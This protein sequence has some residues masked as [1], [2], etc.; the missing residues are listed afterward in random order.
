M[1][2][3]GHLIGSDRVSTR[4]IDR[5][6]FAHDASLYRMVPEAVIRPS[7]SEDVKILLDWCTRTKRHVTFRAAGTSLSGQAV[8]D[9]ILVDL[10][11]DWNRVTVLDDGA[12]IRMQPGITG[13]RVNAHLR[14]FGRKIGPDPASIIAAM[15]GG[16]VANNASGMCCGT[17]QN[18][19][20][21]LSSMSYILANG[22]EIDTSDIDADAT[23]QYLAPDIHAGL[24][25][26]RDDVR[27][28]IDLVETI[29]RKYAIKNTIG[30][31][32]NALLD[33][34]EP[35]R[36]IARLL[37]GSEG[38]LGFIND[39]TLNT[40]VD[41]QA[42]TTGMIIYKSIEEACE[43]V[44][45]W[46]DAGAA[47]VELMDDAS[48]R[49]FADLSS[50]PDHLRVTTSDSAALLV[51]FHD[52]EPPSTVKPIKWTTDIREQSA[53]WRLR[54]GLM[55][56][57]GAMRPRGSTMIN[58][59]IAVPPQHLA[60]LVKDVRAAFVEFG[61]SDAIIFG[62][63]KDGNI[64]FV[65]NQSFESPAKVDQYVRFMKRIS[66]IVIDTYAGSLKAEH[67]TGRNMSPF[68]E[69][70]WGSSAH[71]I[72]R[73]IKN[74]LDPHGILNPGVLLN[75]DPLAHVKNIKPMPWIGQ[76]S[77]ELCIECG[78]CEHVCPSK[79]LTLT[80]RQRIALQRERVLHAHDA[81]TMR[82]IDNSFR[83]DGIATCATDSMCSTVC[84]V[85]ID[86]GTMIKDLRRADISA[87]TNKI[88]S[89]LARNMRV[90][91]G[92]LWLGTKIIR[93]FG[94]S[95]VARANNVDDPEILYVQSCP[96]KWFGAAHGEIPLDEIVKSLVD[97]SGIRLRT[98]ASSDLCC[99]QPFSSK[100]YSGSAH[101]A[102][103]AM[104]KRLLSITRGADI[105]VFVD[106]SSCAAALVSLAKQNGVRIIDQ[107]EFAE[108]L[109]DLLP[110]PIGIAA[111]ALHPGCGAAKLNNTDRFISVARR[112]SPLAFVPPS[113]GCCG[114]GGDR[115]H[116]HPELPISAIHE[117][118]KEIPNG[119]T[120]GVSCNVMCEAAL[121][122]Q[123]G[124]RYT[125][126]L[127]L[128]ERATRH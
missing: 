83:Y 63:A 86:T 7:S 14:Q 107:A 21:T 85:G 122:Q 38:T 88:A 93:K 40:V 102:S 6:A 2:E 95:H 39:V 11:R 12:R 97:R 29:R 5:L 50:T 26:L 55:P 43:T 109:M 120:V 81:K 1:D 115:G 124:I 25:Q 60:A 10:S 100:G 51:E 23:L 116:I 42:K 8:T 79:G 52:I 20:N 48:L 127:H 90:V 31:S 37:I 36:I 104:V 61:Y 110:P 44:P 121:S 108:I 114:M 41:A 16:I 113:A 71:S 56:S 106:T 68:V 24:I 69:K 101:E 30:Y 77:T 103:A 15:I 87:F 126:L 112:C 119:I 105:P 34:D 54:K 57:I 49:S 58:E 78:F 32:L 96:S 99:G 65:I 47:A 128:V 18:S 76:P 28:D 84:P 35:A 4:I 73:R 53:L 33:E 75:D 66:E 3:L 9:G 67:G 111:V 118:A 94:V 72:M 74:L 91:N 117:E 92:A 62:H 13:A 19:Y 89:F 82:E 123:T 45:F 70:E 64:H 125:S 46:R 59:D 22:V 98:I 27:K 80:P 17:A